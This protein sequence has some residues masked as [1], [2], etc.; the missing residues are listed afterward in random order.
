MIVCHFVSDI[1]SMLLCRQIAYTR[2]RLIRNDRQGQVTISLSLR[3]W[4]SILLLQFL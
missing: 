1:I 4:G 2:P 3:T